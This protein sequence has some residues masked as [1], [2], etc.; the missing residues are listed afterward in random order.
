MCHDYEW[1]Y[2]MQRAEEARKAMQKHE[3][4]LKQ[5]PEPAAPATAPKGQEEPVPA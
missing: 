2:L 1:E 4:E 5:K 3:Q